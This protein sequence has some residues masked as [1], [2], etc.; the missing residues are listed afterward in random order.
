MPATLSVLTSVVKSCCKV[1]D[2][3]PVTRGMATYLVLW[4]TG[5]LVQQAMDGT[6]EEW[7]FQEAGR[8]GLYGAFITAPL[9][10]T[11]LKVLTRLIPGS[12]FTQALAKGY[13]DQLVFA[14][15]NI[16]Q[17]FLG[18]ALLEG[19]PPEEALNECQQKLLPTWMISLSIWP[20]LQTL[21]FSLVPEKNRVM[22]ISCGS[23]LWLVFL[24]YMHHTRAQDLPQGLLSRQVHYDYKHGSSES[25]CVRLGSVD[26]STSDT[27]QGWKKAMLP[28]TAL[29][30]G[31]E[32]DSEEQQGPV[33]VVVTKHS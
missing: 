18:M 5:N 19:R 1:V 21:N 4:P 32:D 31:S 24:S 2:R 14:P 7:D 27:Q 20:I 23:F 11:W 3:Y 8:Y 29:C 12:A 33:V 26:F 6:R 30:C 17:F 25:S 9:L 15:V 10:H 13:V 22:A 16:S 28:M